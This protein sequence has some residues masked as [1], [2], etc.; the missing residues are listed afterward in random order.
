MMGRS[1]EI[2]QSDSGYS[3]RSFEAARANTGEAREQWRENRNR[4]GEITIPTRHGV[5]RWWE[6]IVC[7]VRIGRTAG[8]RTER[9]CREI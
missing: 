5:P 3:R 9:G 1:D 2:D 7:R 8:G 6:T 4:G